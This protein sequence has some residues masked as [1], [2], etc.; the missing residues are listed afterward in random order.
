MTHSSRIVE[1]TLFVGDLS[2]SC[3]EANLFEIFST[4]GVVRNIRIMKTRKNTSLGYA[5]V[6]MSSDKEATY[7]METLNGILVSGRK[8]RIGFATSANSKRMVSAGII[9]DPN[10]NVTSHDHLNSVF[11]RFMIPKTAGSN[12]HELSTAGTDEG[13]I[14]DV[15]NERCG[16]NSVSDVSIRRISDDPVR[17]H[18][19]RPLPFPY[20]GNGPACNQGL[21][22]HSFY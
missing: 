19:Q 9:P 11:F 17:K 16:P 10:F 21:R 20:V 15:F 4:C 14:R 8:M 12:L 13:V 1:S 22:V 3:N 6:T 2:V 18:L 5:F 7:A